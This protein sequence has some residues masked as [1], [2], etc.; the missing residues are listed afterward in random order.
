[1]NTFTA[2]DGTRLA[3]HP[4]G[5]G[6]A[7]VCLPGGPMRASAYLGDLGGLSA[8]HRLIL[9][10]L[11][12]TGASAEPTDHATYR[13]DRQVDD[14]E[15][16]RVDLGLDRIDLFGHSAGGTLALAYAARYPHRL[17]RVVLACPSPRAVDLEITADDR[18]RVVEQRRGEPWFAE[19]L[20]ALQ[21]VMAGTGTSGDEAA[22]APFSHG[23]WDAAARA[24][25]ALGESQ[26]S[27][28]AAKA[29]YSAGGVDPQAIRSA[30][31]HLHAP[32]LLL[33]GEYDLAV[34]PECAA[35]YAGLFLHAELVVQP[36]AGHNGW[37]DDPQWFVETVTRF[38]GG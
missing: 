22:I 3:Y 26:R 7:L 12:G 29:Y 2:P 14:V 15:A 32:V 37:L 36:G 21:R 13:R 8:H 1:M 20:P 30:L 28:M 11:R 5:D 25:D 38:L 33:A 24:Y 16:L 17:G 9:L 27:A 4:V 6:A 34:P 35:R 19:A 18:R 31:S 23:R 10:D